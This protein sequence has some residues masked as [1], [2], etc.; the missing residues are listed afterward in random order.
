[1]KYNKW[2]DPSKIYL[3][4]MLAL[5]CNTRISSQSLSN[6]CYTQQTALKQNLLKY[7][8]E[9]LKNYETLP[10]TDDSNSEPL[11]SNRC[12][13]TSKNIS[14][15]RASRHPTIILKNPNIGLFLKNC[16]SS[17]TRDCLTT[18]VL[19][20]SDHIIIKKDLQT[21][22]CLIDPLRQLNYLI[23]QLISKKSKQHHYYIL[24]TIFVDSLKNHLYN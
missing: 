23:L 1:M 10:T 14:F 2:R 16:S 6:F 21:N 3:Y 24:L 22:L 19:Q 9:L 20:K 17:L 5:F 12:S 18:T 8:S 7:E 15:S 13:F 11:S 4:K